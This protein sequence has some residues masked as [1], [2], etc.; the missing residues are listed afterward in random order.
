MQ[1]TYQEWCQRTT[2]PN[3]R[4]QKG[5]IKTFEEAMENYIAQYRHELEQTRR[6][7]KE[8]PYEEPGR[9]QREYMEQH[10]GVAHIEAMVEKAKEIY[11]R[12]MNAVLGEIADEMRASKDLI[13]CDIAQAVRT[14]NWERLA[15]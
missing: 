8:F 1:E 15:L 6:L 10:K 9:N 4:F 7:G 13:L 3:T 5:E 2:H 12:R 14:Q 11:H